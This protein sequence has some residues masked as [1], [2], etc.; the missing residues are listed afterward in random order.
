MEQALNQGQEMIGRLRQ[1]RTAFPEKVPQADPFPGLPGY[2]AV[3]GQEFLPGVPL[4]KGMDFILG[5]Q[6]EI[7]TG[8]QMVISVTLFGSRTVGGLACGRFQEQKLTGDLTVPAPAHVQA[9]SKK[10]PG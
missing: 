10:E 6:G 2:L 9:L 3:K 8:E 5:F 1:R 4:K 7:G